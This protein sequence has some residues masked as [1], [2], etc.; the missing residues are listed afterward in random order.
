MV[1]IL[2][3]PQNLETWC[4]DNYFLMRFISNKKLSSMHFLDINKL[5]RLNFMKNV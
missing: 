5:R 2:D 3:K 1:T 4:T